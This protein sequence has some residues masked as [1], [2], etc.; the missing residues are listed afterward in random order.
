MVPL[1]L[2]LPLADALEAPVALAMLVVAHLINHPH[3]AHSYT[4]FDGNFRRKLFGAEYSASLKTR[5]RYAF[6]GL[7]VPAAVGV[8]SAGGVVPWGRPGC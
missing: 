8:L 2:M 3:F 5:L 1:W 7:I 4:K 6:A